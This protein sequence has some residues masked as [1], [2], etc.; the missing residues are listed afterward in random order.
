MDLQSPVPFVPQWQIHD[1]T[2]LQCF[3]SC[4]RRY[5]YEHVLGWRSDRPSIHLIYGSAVHTALEHLLLNG[6]TEGAIPGAFQAFLTEYRKVFSPEDDL[7]QAPKDPAT[8]LSLLIQYV[9]AHPEYAE[10]EVVRPEIVGTVPIAEGRV[11]HFKM[12]AIVRH[13]GRIFSFEHKTVGRLDKNWTAQWQTSTQIS[14]YLHALYCLFDPSDVDGVLVN[15]LSPQKKESKLQQ[16]LIR[17]TFSMMEA[18]LS[19]VNY[20][21]DLIDASFVELSSATADDRYLAAFPRNDRHCGD[22]GGCPWLDFC[23]A[24]SNPLRRADEPPSGFHTE[25]WDPRSKLSQGNELV[26]LRPAYLDI[27]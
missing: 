10:L 5:F 20:W 13:K 2:K 11:L 14:V 17:K 4:P 18:W 27:K 24:W 23:S 25:H 15:A 1:A 6:H 12:D 16:I 3:M 19:D 26:E 7:A 8:F 9:D 22:Y 21:H